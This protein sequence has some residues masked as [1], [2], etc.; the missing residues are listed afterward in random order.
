M[1]LCS[2][3]QVHCGSAACL[4]GAVHNDQKVIFFLWP[5]NLYLFVSVAEIAVV[6]N[7]TASKR[8]LYKREDA[9]K[10]AHITCLITV[11]TICGNSIIPK[12][13]FGEMR[14]KY[15]CAALPVINK[16]ASKRNLYKRGDADK[17]AHITCLITVCT[18]CGNSI[19]P[20][21]GF[22]EMRLKYICAALPGHAHVCVYT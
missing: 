8:N 13:G 12:S 21:S 22:G 19:I 5:N 17:S 7:K 1:V 16:T 20:K 15:I 10:S 2:S 3:L 4:L 18:I 9:D 6:I 14:L 11:C